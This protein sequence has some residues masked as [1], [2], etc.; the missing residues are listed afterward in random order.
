MKQR[1]PAKS[2]LLAALVTA[3]AVQAQTAPAAGTTNL[4]PG[5]GEASTQVNGQPNR[6][7]NNP[8]LDAGASSSTTM[9]AGAQNGGMH[10]D[11]GMSHDK[12]MS[13]DSS[14]TSTMGAGASHGGMHS[15]MSHGS[16]SDARVSTVP[17][18]AG[19]ASTMVNGR[20]NAQPN[21]P[22]LSKG[23]EELR[24]EKEMKRAEARQRRELAVMGQR[25]ATAGAPAGTPAVTHPGNPS[26]FQGGTPQ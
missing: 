6:N 2:L 3:G 5:S 25:G 20:P 18:K 8:A 9:G 11:M 7:P 13:H 26:V 24:S 15:G 1:F 19:E 16:G 22:R 10:K 23:S 17:P 4:P 12:S 21:D 14:S